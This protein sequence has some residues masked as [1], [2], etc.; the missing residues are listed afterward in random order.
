MPPKDSRK[1]RSRAHGNRLPRRT[2]LCLLGL[3]SLVSLILRYPFSLHETGV[4]SFFVHNLAAAIL[5]EGRASW[6]LNPLGLVGWYPLSYP[7]ASPFIIADFSALSGVPVEGSILL[8]SLGYGLIGT[9]ASFAMAKEFRSDDEFALIACFIYGLAPRLLDFTLWTASARGLFMALLPIFVW[10]LLRAKRDPRATN[11]I[12]V[13]VVFFVLMATHRLAALMLAVVAALF[14]AAILVTVMRIMRRRLPTVMLSARVKQWSPYLA[15]GL[16]ASATVVLLFGFGLLQ[17]YSTG[18][19]FNGTTTLD[20]LGNL[21]V[22]LAR[23]VGLGLILAIIGIVAIG[24][25]NNKS[26]REPFV[27]LSFLALTPTLFLRVY[28]G[29]YVLPFISLLG[30]TG[31]VYLARFRTRR[32]RIATVLV[33]LA[34]CLGFSGYVLQYEI[35]NSTVLPAST[36]DLS[37]YIHTEAWQGSLISNDGLL[38]VRVASISGYAYLPVGGAGTTFQSP[39]LLIYGFVNATGAEQ[40]VYAVPLG[41]ISID[42]DSPWFDST[43][44]AEAV[45]VKML[46]SPMAGGR[47]Q[48]DTFHVT[49][50]LENRQLTGEYLA[51]GNVYTSPFAQSVHQEGYLVYTDPLQSLWYAPQSAGQ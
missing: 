39:E 4:D 40:S 43:I 22:S 19:I 35:G 27:V 7:S 11:I 18:E 8:L 42:T 25:M 9:V 46:Q 33:V 23:S 14:G 1:L 50:F 12:L 32:V 15:L 29:F 2:T 30:A 47:G 51:F 16:V 45:W 6:I 17:E 28:T 48:N 3:I 37:V 44:Q 31:L 20:E 24:R 34:V 5:R 49:Y 41:D 21:V 36:Y 38:G 13:L 26:F 10:C